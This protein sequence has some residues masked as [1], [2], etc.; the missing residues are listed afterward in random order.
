[1]SI[2]VNGESLLLGRESLN[3]SHYLVADL[4]L[5]AV[6]KNGFSG[7]VNYHQVFE[8][9]AYGVQSLQLGVRKEL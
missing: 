4:G 9:R 3:D 5:S 8:H 6:F 1:L 2:S 7:Y